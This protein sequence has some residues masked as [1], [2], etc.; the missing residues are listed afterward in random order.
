MPF[1][2]LIRPTKSAYGARTPWRA[3]ASCRSVRAKASASTPL[4]ITTT[5]SGS[6]WKW[7][8]MSPRIWADT[9]MTRSARSTASRSAQLDTA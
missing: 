8:R 2:S 4:W 1:C 3:S 9:A 5:R 7:V 6:T